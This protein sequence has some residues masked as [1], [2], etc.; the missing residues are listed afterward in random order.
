MS[1]HIPSHRQGPEVP[2]EKLHQLE[3]Y[4]TSNVIRRGNTTNTSIAAGKTQLVSP[5]KIKSRAI[6]RWV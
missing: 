5:V 2:R 3:K 4:N 6:D 1:P